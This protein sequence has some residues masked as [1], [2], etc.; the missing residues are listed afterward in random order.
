VTVLVVEDNEADYVRLAD[1]LR[2]SA[3]MQYDLVRRGSYAAG[4][5][6]A[7]QGGIDVVLLAWHLAA[8]PGQPLAGGM[9]EQWAGL[10]VILLAPEFTP[11]VTAQAERAGAADFLGKSGLTLPQVEQAIR[12]ARRYAT[13][14]QALRRSRQQLELFMWAVPCAMCICDARG[15]IL[16]Q[17]TLSQEHF[18]EADLQRWLK[19]NGTGVPEVH[20]ARGR[21]W[22]VSTFPMI[23]ADRVQLL[24]VAGTDITSH[25]RSEAELRRT[26]RLLNAIL[27]N[28]SVMAGRLAPDGTVLEMRGRGLTEMGLKE[29]HLVGA[30]LPGR[31]P[32]VRPAFERAL[33]GRPT[34]VLWDLEHNGRR[35]FFETYFHADTVQ[36]GVL[37]LAIDVTARIEAEAERN[38]QSSLLGNVLKKLPVLVGQLDHTGVV[39][40]VEGE[41]LEWNGFRPA[42]LLGLELAALHPDCRPRVAQAL[43]GEEVNFTLQGVHEGNPW[44]LDFHIAPYENGGATFFG[45][46]VTERRWLERRL[47]MAAD[48]EQRRIGADLHDGLGQKLT[49][50]A[51]LAAAVRERT[52]NTDP[53]VAEQANTVARLA[54]EA[55]Q[56]ARALARGLCPVELEEAGLV[57][58]LTGLV[59][60]TRVLHEVECEIFCPDESPPCEHPVSIHLYRITQEAITNAIRHAQARHIQVNLEPDGDVYRLIIRDDGAGFAVDDQ[61]IRRSHGLRLMKFRATMIGASLQVTSQPGRGTRICC[62]FAANAVASPG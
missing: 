6:T 30:I 62:E 7:G 47:L 32:V 25:V 27:G 28:L 22:L 31:W 34:T 51:C 48:L 41:G 44:Y 14:L 42:E 10:P 50:L 21:H 61:L 58:A 16:F 24:G 40:A 26:S 17:N 57:A 29:E 59:E 52:R 1:L 54:N 53:D 60:Q 18:S 55:V 9:D 33:R 35:H 13:T 46:D 37:A 20:V 49:G 43:A 39:V 11:Q 15:T 5:E 23:G 4:Q 8:A 36:G 45:R 56:Q 3:S 19:P 38:R 12:H 2:E